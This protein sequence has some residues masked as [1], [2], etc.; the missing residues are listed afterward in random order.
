MTAQ[1]EDIS[2]PAV[3]RRFADLVG[4]RTRLDYLYLL[5]VAD[6]RATNPNLW[7]DWKDTL[8]RDLY[9]ATRR[10]LLHGVD[11]R[12]PATAELARECR[13]EARR[14][15]AGSGPATSRLEDLWETLEPEYFVLT[16]PEAVAWHAAEVLGRDSSS[17]VAVRTHRKRTEV[18]FHVPDQDHLFAA[19]TT[20]LE[21]AGLTVVDARVFTTGTGMSFD[22]FTVAE[23]TGEPIE[24]D[25]RRDEIRRLLGRG[26]EE[27][28]KAAYPTN[29][30]PR[31]QMKSFRIPVRVAFDERPAN[32]RTV[33]EVACADRPGVL[34]RI[35][36][37]LAGAG[38]S[39]HGAKI[40]TF[41][42]RAEDVFRLT[43]RSG[44]PL[45]VTERERLRAHILRALGPRD[46]D[47]PPVTGGKNATSSPS[48]T[49]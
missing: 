39:V 44:R 1:R 5:T 34:S 45:D 11:E 19:A 21:R 10:V 18:F 3:V 36:W 22:S 23:P 38:A 25:R 29:R 46:G 31:R 15:L 48:A 26:L 49:G 8:L 9:Q 16:P 27:P 47:Q 6:M 17:V 40:A 20:I 32:G 28:E 33:M 4:D 35:G 2:D 7:T 41:G 13:D 43:N 37:A 42:E 30:L 24:D 14:Q 12:L